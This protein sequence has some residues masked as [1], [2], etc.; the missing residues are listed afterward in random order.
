[1][2][3]TKREIE[4]EQDLIIQERRKRLAKFKIASDEQASNGQANNDLEGLDEQ[5]LKE[6]DGLDEQPNNDLEGLDEEQEE[7]ADDMFAD[8]FDT[9][10]GIQPIVRSGD[11]PALVDNWD[12]QEGYY[13]IIVGEVLHS[14]YH[15]TCTLGKGVFSNVV[16]AKDTIENRDV[17]IK[18]I[19]NNDLMTNA[20]LK[21]WELLERCS[22]NDSLDRKHVVRGLDRFEYRGHLCLVFENLE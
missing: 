8:D 7:P 12:D 18:I 4:D 16:R 13:N 22:R 3:K 2:F 9:K 14:R 20:G 5:H 17:A 19:R 1:M 21:E 6:Q 15:L 11:N 10:K